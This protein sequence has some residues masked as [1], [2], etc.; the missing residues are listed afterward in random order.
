MFSEIISGQQ[1]PALFSPL[2]RRC[3]DF[4]PIV[5][6]DILTCHRT[7]SKAA[8]MDSKQLAKLANDASSR[9]T[10]QRKYSTTTG[11]E[12]AQSSSLRIVRARCYL[13]AAVVP[14]CQYVAAADKQ[15]NTPEQ[16]DPN[17]T[18]VATA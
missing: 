9:R 8:S 5:L 18:T 3:E 15:P 13:V 12:R 10:N 4:M 2:P 7:M 16:D 1:A 17:M 14:H 11:G 6:M